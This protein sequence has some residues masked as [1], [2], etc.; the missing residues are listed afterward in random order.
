MGMSVER[1]L[2]DLTPAAYEKWW[3]YWLEEPWGPWRDNLHTAILAREIQRPQLKKGHKVDMQNFMVQRP[4][5][6]A[7]NRVSAFI[8]TLFAMSKPVP[9]SGSKKP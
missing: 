4:V 1:M 8:R 7:Q 3:R 5:E 2:E 6:Q 9:K